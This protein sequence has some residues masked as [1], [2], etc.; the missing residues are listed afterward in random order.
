MLGRFIRARSDAAAAIWSSRVNV[1]RSGRWGGSRGAKAGDSAYT[2][3]CI[4]RTL[5]AHEDR[6]ALVVELGASDT[7]D[8]HP[9]SPLDNEV[10]RSAA[11]I[12]L[13]LPHL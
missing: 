13:V 2:H 1:S 8:E 4:V 3:G 5:V 11:L 12:A 9:W 7:L 6:A 10:K